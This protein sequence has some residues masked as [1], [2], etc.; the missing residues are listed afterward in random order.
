MGLRPSNKNFVARVVN[1]SS[2]SCAM[3]VP[4]ERSQ[5]VTV[6]KFRCAVEEVIREG[7]GPPKWQGTMRLPSGS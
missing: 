2:K 6:Y 7:T 5:Y 1:A 4:R 3:L